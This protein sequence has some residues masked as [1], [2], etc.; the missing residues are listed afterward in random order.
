M[1]DVSG[2]VVPKCDPQNVGEHQMMIFLGAFSP[3]FVAKK[4]GDSPPLRQA[5][6]VGPAG[7]GVLAAEIVAYGV[8]EDVGLAGDGEAGG[9]VA[10]D[11]LL[12]TEDDGLSALQAVDAVHDGVEAA[13]LLELLGIDVEEVLL[14]GG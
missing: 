12:A 14:Q 1:P 10:A 5:D 6:D 3:P 2:L 13:Q 7:G 8:G 11:V 9:G 4:R